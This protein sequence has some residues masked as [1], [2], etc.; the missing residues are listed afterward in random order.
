MAA[1]NRVR[2]AVAV[3]VFA[4]GVL[5]L[6]CA[7]LIRRSP[8]PTRQIAPRIDIRV[9]RHHELIEEPRASTLLVTPPD[10]EPT[11]P[12]APAPMVAPD[13]SPN[14]PA[15]VSRPPIGRTVAV[16]TVLP[17]DM[18]AMLRTHASARPAIV[19]PAVRP[20]AAR[21]A[22]GGLAAGQRVVYLLDAS[23]SMGEWGKYDAARATLAATLALQ[24]AA[25]EVK[26]VVYAATPEVV[27]PAGLAARTPAGRSN[28]VAGVR[29]ALDLMPDFVVWFTDADDLPAAT[30]RTLAR[31]IGK[32]VTVVVARVGSEGVAAP[33][34][35][36]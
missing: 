26:V 23:G 27:S 3:S 16:P 7:I 12:A 6:A 15:E 18:L 10:P 4:H 24:T 25:V 11:P 36:R 30:I 31:R 19:D 5:V 21:P 29:A 17:P 32:S 35:L 1:G 33:A 28:H 8:E 34:E 20:A 22:H 13:P 14:P 2:R 9:T